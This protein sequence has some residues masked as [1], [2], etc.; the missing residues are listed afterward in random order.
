MKNLEDPIGNRN[1]D[2]PA[3]SALPRPTTLTCLLTLSL[4]IS[5]SVLSSQCSRNPRLLWQRDTWFIS[6]RC[7]LKRLHIVGGMIMTGK[8]WS[9]Q[10]NTWHSATLST[11]NPRR[12]SPECNPGLRYGT[13]TTNHLPLVRT[14]SPWSQQPATWLQSAPSGLPLL[15][16]ELQCV[17]HWTFPDVLR[18][19]LWNTWWILNFLPHVTSSVL[20]LALV[21]NLVSSVPRC[22]QSMLFTYGNRSSFKPTQNRTA[23]LY[24]TDIK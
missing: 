7:H 12:T 13:P 10:R 6:W 4:S 21:L 23:G 15:R 3:G 8:N 19:K 17:L 9:T 1:R 5:L 20:R 16:Q 14:G 2:L 11:T 18:P 24:I 22:P